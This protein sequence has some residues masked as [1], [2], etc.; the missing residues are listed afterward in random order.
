MYISLGVF[1][2]SYIFL[3]TCLIVSLMRMLTRD[4]Q[5]EENLY[6][7]FYEMLSHLWQSLLEKMKALLASQLAWLQRLVEMHIFARFE[8]WRGCTSAGG[9]P[10]STEAHGLGLLSAHLSTFDVFASPFFSLAITL[11]RGGGNHWLATV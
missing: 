3:C 10:A 6:V 4:R 2:V 9:I 1:I 8:R 11:R 7:C 5:S